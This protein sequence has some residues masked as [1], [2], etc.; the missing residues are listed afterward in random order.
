MLNKLTIIAHDAMSFKQRIHEL[1]TANNN[2]LNDIFQAVHYQDPRVVEWII[3]HKNI[4]N[5]KLILATH[6]KPVPEVVW[7]FWFGSKLGPVRN[8][9]LQTIIDNI[10]YPVILVTDETL[11]Y[12]NLS[13][14][15]IHPAFEYLSGIHKG[16]YMR[17]YFMHH[18]GGGYHDVKVHKNSWHGQ[19]D[20]FKNKTK[21]VWGVLIREFNRGG[22]ACGAEWTHIEKWNKY[23][24]QT[25]NIIH[26]CD[27]KMEWWSMILKDERCSISANA[28][29]C[30]V[31][32]DQWE[33]LGS[34]GIYLLRPN[35]LFTR[36]WLFEIET[37]LNQR[38]ELL[39]LHPSPSPRCCLDRFTD[40]D[41]AYPM[42][43]SDFHGSLF[44]PLLLLH[45]GHWEFGLPIWLF[46]ANHVDENEHR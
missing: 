19:F 29:C 34:N 9:S 43:W 20:K 24:D 16:D 27:K 14:S 44:H 2:L 31:L 40:E 37:I 30:E 28:R 10:G 18:F 4:E 26:N 36:D 3:N 1:K 25:C 32:G 41:K 8:S 38:H 6:A 22:V 11:P 35:T 45:H 39:R 42:G 21:D 12:Y 17:A 13:F 46:G 15:P 33:K 7:V 23:I 5:K